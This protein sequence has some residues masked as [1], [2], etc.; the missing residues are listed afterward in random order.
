MAGNVNLALI[1]QALG[2]LQHQF[3]DEVHRDN[4]QR[5]SRVNLAGF[6][7][8]LLSEMVIPENQLRLLTKK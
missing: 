5:G 8:A 4:G 2:P 3:D 1:K 6:D 7:G